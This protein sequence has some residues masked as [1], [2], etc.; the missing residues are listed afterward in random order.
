MASDSAAHHLAAG[1]AS[2]LVVTTLTQPFDLV[3]TRLQQGDPLPSSA[4]QKL[5]GA[6]SLPNVRHLQTSASS[7]HHPSIRS[8]VKSVIHRNGVHGLWRGTIPTLLRYSICHIIPQKHLFYV[9]MF[10]E[11]HCISPC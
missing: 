3:K 2:S 10:Q 7:Q 8:V 11:R 9:E 1:A 5:I 4:L 6:S